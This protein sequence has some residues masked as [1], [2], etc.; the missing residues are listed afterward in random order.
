[1]GSADVERRTWLAPMAGRR[2]AGGYVLREPIGE[3]G[4]GLVWRARD[5]RLE[6]DVA[7][8]FVKAQGDEGMYA[9]R[10]EREAKA[11]ARLNHPALVTVFDCRRGDDG[12]PFVVMELL[13]GESLADWSHVRGA[14]GADDAVRLMLPVLDGLQAAHAV[15]VVH[16]DLK[17]DNIF[18]ARG[19]DGVVRPKII[20][21]GIAHLDS[22]R[23]D[24]TVGLIGTPE[25]M[26]P[27][28][29]V[30][31]EA[32]G[33]AADQWAACIC[34]Y[35]LASGQSPFSGDFSQLFRAIREAPLPFPRNGSIDGRLFRIL[36][37]GT[38][39]S[40][41]DRFG[42]VGE[43]RDALLE[44]QRQR[45]REGAAPPARSRQPLATPLDS[46]VRAKLRGG[47]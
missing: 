27:E 14:A 19:A 42:S 21:F 40:P 34:L 30:L 2:L 20:D 12:A 31:G 41:G 47:S 8:K 11:L 28:Q 15:G 22:V 4:M 36:A 23:S 29:V 32:V 43:L 37:K 44:W 5:P 25:F 45:Q 1:M 3:G 39:K 33:P 10:L 35:V 16:R 13:Q 46:L 18:L 6:R 24:L 9:A 26:A 38:R 7:V 17:L